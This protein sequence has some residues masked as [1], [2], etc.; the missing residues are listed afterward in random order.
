[1]YVG[2]L[3]LITLY[4]LSNLM[5]QKCSGSDVVSLGLST[6]SWVFCQGATTPP[7]PIAAL[8]FGSLPPYCLVVVPPPPL[9]TDLAQHDGQVTLFIRVT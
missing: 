9:V 3:T 2:I 7:T 5:A 6:F 4:V 1:M 8:Q